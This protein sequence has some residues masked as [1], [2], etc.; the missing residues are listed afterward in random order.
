MQAT[1]VSSSSP[2]TG[3]RLFFRQSLDNEKPGKR[4]LISTHT[5]FPISRTHARTGPREA[6]RPI[7][8][9]SATR[10]AASGL[11]GRNS[12]SR[13]SGKDVG[14]TQPFWSSSPTLHEVILR[15]H[16]RPPRTLS[17]SA[18]VPRTGRGR[19]A[20]FRPDVDLSN[21][22]A[23]TSAFLIRAIS[24]AVILTKGGRTT[25]RGSF[26][27]STSASF[28]RLCMSTNGSA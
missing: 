11:T 24:G 20:A 23:S 26:P 12:G 18:C 25:A 15:H 6:M 28:M 1:P 8:R 9:T 7:K 4:Y 27:S 3:A 5:G 14:M 10:M 21:R 13:R 17:A 19:Y 2:G 22:P 16:F